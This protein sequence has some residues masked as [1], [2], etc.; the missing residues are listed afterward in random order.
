MSLRYTIEGLDEDQTQKVVDVLQE[1]LV[2]LLDLQLTLKHIHWNVV[3]PNF[4]AV[5]EMLDPQTETIRRATDNTAER[6]ATIGGTPDGTPGKVVETRTWE[7]YDIGT[8]SAQEHL[9]SLDAV[10][11]GIIKDHRAAQALVADIDPV[12]EDLIIGQLTELEM[13]QW[14]VRSHLERAAD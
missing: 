8:A 2:A 10:Y 9:R 14:F 11:S 5:H 3:G 13:A 6:I 1:R 12:T 4:V 7:N